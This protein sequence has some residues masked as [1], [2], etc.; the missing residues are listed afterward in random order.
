MKNK[1]GILEKN[2]QD[3]TTLFN[4]GYHCCCVQQ[5]NKTQILPIRHR[6]KKHPNHDRNSGQ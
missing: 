1:N 3:Y 5:L 6:G 2:L 4:K